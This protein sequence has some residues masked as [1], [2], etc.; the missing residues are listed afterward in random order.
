[1]LSINSIFFIFFPPD[2]GLGL[3]LGVLG[4]AGAA[5]LD[6]ASLAGPQQAGI[7]FDT[8][9]GGV[10]GPAVDG[11]EKFMICLS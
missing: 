7:A 8:G 10:G 2:L 5:A 6:I 4:G 11:M 9:V 1:M 3:D